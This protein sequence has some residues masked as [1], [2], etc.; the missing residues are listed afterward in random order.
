MLCGFWRFPA[1]V[2]VR[3]AVR[4]RGRVHAWSSSRCGVVGR[5]AVSWGEQVCDI[6]SAGDG[7]GISERKFLQLPCLPSSHW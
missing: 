2:V 4:G 7:K 5:V 1:E 6:V 3:G